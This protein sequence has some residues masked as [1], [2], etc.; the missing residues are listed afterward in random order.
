LL[1]LIALIFCF[2]VIR[3][4]GDGSPSEM[5]HKKKR[6]EERGEKFKVEIT[7]AAKISMKAL[8]AVIQGE[9][10]DKAQDALRV[11]DI[12]LRQHASRKYELVHLHLVN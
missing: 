11:L 6:R 7:F 9:V 1:I 12:V 4:I 5:D 8:Q 3:L 2:Y 10:S